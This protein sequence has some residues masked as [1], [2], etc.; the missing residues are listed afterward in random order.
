MIWR[1]NL[2]LFRSLPRLRPPVR[3]RNPLGRSTWRSA[4][5]AAWIRTRRVRRVLVTLALLGL[6]AVFGWLVFR[7]FYH[8]NA[9]MAFLSGT[10]YHA[11]QAP[12]ASFAIEDFE[13]MKGRDGITPFLARQGSATGPLA[14]NFMRSPATMG[15]LASAIADAVPDGNGVMMIYVDAHGVSDDG[16]PYLLCRNFDPANP[17]AGRYPLRDL[18]AQFSASTASVKLL[19]PRCGAHSLRSA[20]GNARERISTAA[21]AR[22]RAHGRSEA[23]GAEFQ[24]GVPTI[25]CFHGT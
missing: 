19:D 6:V 17:A 11:L 7:P 12:P 4:P 23:V 2:K 13:A 18:L 21:G 20:A 1:I 22:G 25:A 8:P 15:S 14:W 9:Q 10:D 24:R 16:V 3:A 5:L